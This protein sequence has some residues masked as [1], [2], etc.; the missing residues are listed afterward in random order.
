V[1]REAVLRV[2]RVTGWMQW[3][4]VPEFSACDGL[5][6]GLEGFPESPSG[7]GGTQASTGRT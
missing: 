5:A 4:G 2:S 1:R 7:L 6:G 3:D